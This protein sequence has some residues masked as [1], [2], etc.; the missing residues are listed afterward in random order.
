[1]RRG[2][3]SA[4]AERHLARLAADRVFI[5]GLALW[6]S[7]LVFL[8]WA[9][10]HRVAY[11]DPGA[12]LAGLRMGVWDGTAVFRAVVALLAV[13]LGLTMINS[14][15]RAGTLF[16]VLARPVSRTEVYLGAW[17]AA[18]GLLVLLELV[19]LGVALT[20]FG[21][22]GGELDRPLIVGV[23]AGLAETPL[24]LA[25]CAV[26]GT[27]LPT[28]YALLTLLGVHIAGS[29]AIAGTVGG[30]GRYALAAVAAFF[31]VLG[32]QPRVVGDLFV[33]QSRDLAQGLEILAYRLCWTGLLLF[34]GI[35]VFRRRDL[36]PRI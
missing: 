14:D 22:N 1:M 25:L 2:A 17:I 26:L 23:L 3:L 8:G 28:A 18:A 6:V 20:F 34:I 36:A 7:S 5:V 21:L 30:A 27:L 15:V 12:S 13:F 9:V 33:G 10:S 35:W 24:L 16:H 31:P 4:I 29:L 19:F 11:L 32:R